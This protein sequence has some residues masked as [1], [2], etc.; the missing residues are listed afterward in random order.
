MLIDVDNTNEVGQ[1][2]R[3]EPEKWSWREELWH[4]ASR[5]LL[6]RRSYHTASDCHVLG[7]FRV[8]TWPTTFVSRPQC[9]SDCDERTYHIKQTPVDTVRGNHSWYASGLSGALQTSNF[10]VSFTTASCQKL[11]FD[12]RSKT[13]V[14]RW[15]WN[16]LQDRSRLGRDLVLGC[17]ILE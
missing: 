4:F 15:P 9:Q 14:T 16:R 7:T 13:R 12:Q 2:S 11:V 1:T 17:Q 5:R 8:A 3:N 10:T 6:T